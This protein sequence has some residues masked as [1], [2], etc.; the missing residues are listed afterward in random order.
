MR[1]KNFWCYRRIILSRR[2]LRTAWASRANVLADVNGRP[3]S[4]GPYMVEFDITYRCNCRCRMCQRW[5]DPRPESLSLSDYRRLAAEFRELAIHQISIAGGEPL[6]RQD[7]FE[8]IGAFKKS[9][10]SVNLCTNG[11]LLERF[12]AQIAGSGATCVT[13]SLDGAAAETHDAI[14]GIE[15]SYALIERGIHKLL[16]VDRKKRPVLRVRMTVSNHNQDQIKAFYRKWRGVADDVLLQPVHHCGD[17]YYT[18]MPPA[19]LRLD[20][21]VL[22][23]QL[24]GTALAG[25]GYTGTLI[26]SLEQSG[27]YPRRRCYAGVLM[28]RIDPWGNVYPC[29][30]QHV[31]VGSVQ[32]RSFHDVWLSD[33]FE[34]ERHRLRSSRPC[35][36][37]Y[38]NTALIGYYGDQ[39]R[40][41][42]PAGRKPELPAESASEPLRDDP[43]QR[44]N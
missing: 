26:D 34:R 2:F 29:L 11:M 7:V 12:C 41:T 1:F 24:R 31:R 15:G 21:L 27:V 39:L 8:I 20:P 13:V 32:G 28:A 42:G 3:P 38:N 22:R 19:D 18:G 35:R 10:F 5:N 30:E 17:A 6:M 33:D 16:S 14:R 25:D 37:W 23:D 44:L 40:K 4:A 36:C 9:G 43:A